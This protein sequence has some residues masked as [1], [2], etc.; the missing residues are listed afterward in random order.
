MSE[1]T[2]V[3]DKMF[4]QTR[5]EHSNVVI[6][7]LYRPQCRSLLGWVSQFL[8]CM[9]DHLSFESPLFCGPANEIA[10]LRCQRVLWPT[11]PVGS[12]FF[13]SVIALERRNRNPSTSGVAAKVMDVS[14]RCA[15]I[16]VTPCS[17]TASCSQE[18]HTFAHLFYHLISS[19]IASSHILQGSEAPVTLSWYTWS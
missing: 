11:H 12:S 6:Q 13:S 9:M 17:F 7:L 15:P 10:L 19:C 16:W 18:V 1:C 5:V 3:F 4:V 8:M 2:D 14:A